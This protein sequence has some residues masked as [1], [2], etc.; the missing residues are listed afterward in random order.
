MESFFIFLQVDVWDEGGPVSGRLEPGALL[1]AAECEPS[2]D[3]A[4]ERVGRRL[5]E[6]RHLVRRLPLVSLVFNSDSINHSNFK[7]YF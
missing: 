3:L 1:A 2:A 6:H 7:K 5:A 4:P